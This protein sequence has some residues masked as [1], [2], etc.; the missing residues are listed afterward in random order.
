M[1]VAELEA[2]IEE[3]RIQNERLAGVMQGGDFKTM[4]AAA[5]ASSS[6]P[7]IVFFI[8]EVALQL[9]EL[10]EQLKWAIGINGIHVVN[11]DRD[12]GGDPAS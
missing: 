6:L 2:K 8:G 7:A 5:I 9:A 11:R 1:K 10:N 3:L 4:T 12:R